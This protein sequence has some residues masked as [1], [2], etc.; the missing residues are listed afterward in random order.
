M[1]KIVYNNEMVYITKQIEYINSK[2]ILY[3]RLLE[4]PTKPILY[5]FL[6]L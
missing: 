3:H 6:Y 5:N 1:G 4:G 2:I